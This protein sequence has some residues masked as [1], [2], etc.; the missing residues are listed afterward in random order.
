MFCDDVTFAAEQLK[1][2][3]GGKIVDTVVTEDNE[4]YGFVVEVDG[5]EKV[6]WVDMDPEGNGPGWIQIQEKEK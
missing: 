1:Q 2:L 5:K 4:N 6:C 3:V